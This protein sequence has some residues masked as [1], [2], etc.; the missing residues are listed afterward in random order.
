[1]PVI[2]LQQSPSSAAR[3]LRAV[4]DGVLLSWLLHEQQLFDLRKRGDVGGSDLHQR[5]GVRC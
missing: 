2:V 1:M 4:F 5:T 3:G